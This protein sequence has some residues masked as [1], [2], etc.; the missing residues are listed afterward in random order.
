M[1][2]R[3]RACSAKRQARRRSCGAPRHASGRGALPG[4]GRRSTRAVPLSQGAAG[5]GM[6]TAPVSSPM[7]W[8]HACNTETCPESQARS[9]YQTLYLSRMAW[10]ATAVGWPRCRIAAVSDG[11]WL[12]IAAVSDG[13]WLWIAA[14]S[15]GRWL[16]IAA[17]SDGRWLWIA[18]V[19]DGRWLWIAAGLPSRSRDHWRRMRAPSQRKAQLA[20][21]AFRERNQQRHTQPLPLNEIGAERR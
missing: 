12:W 16:W 2:R 3:R 17:V 1:S 8:S 20:G 9:V 19:S 11:R 10:I 6:G 21:C 13:R 18:A 5:E 4:D 7:R 14:V 15:D